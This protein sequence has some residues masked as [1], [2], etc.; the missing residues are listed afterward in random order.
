MTRAASQKRI[1]AQKKWEQLEQDLRDQL[2]GKAET[3]T[4]LSHEEIADRREE[5]SNLLAEA[6]E[7]EGLNSLERMMTHDGASE[8]ARRIYNEAAGGTTP[9]GQ[10]RR[11]TWKSF[12]QFMRAV[13]GVEQDLTPEQKRAL[14]VAREGARAMAHGDP[15]SAKSLEEMESKTLVGD[16]SGSTGRGDYLVPAEHMAELI[17]AMGESQ[18]FLNRTRRIPM[19]RPTAK[20]PRLVQDDGDNTRPIFGFAAVSKIAEGAQKPEREPVFEQVTLQSH[21][22]AAYLEASD[23]LL[24]DS[25]VPAQPLLASLLTEAIAYEADRDGMRGSG[26]GEPQGFIGSDAE[27]EVNRQASVDVQLSDIFN[28]EER[29]FGSD[30]VYLFHPSLIP[31]LYGLADSNVIVFHPNL[32]ESA[33]ATLL[34]RPLIR[35]SKLP[36]LGNT[37][38]LSLVDPQMYLSGVV[39]GIVVESSI[40]YQFRND[41]T[42]FRAIARIA[43]VPALGGTLSHEASGGTK[44]FEVS[45]F[46]VLSAPAS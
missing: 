22:Y 43:G 9:G 17:R 15:I 1:D 27:Y 41:V 39:N 4:R 6:K 28:M 13:A 31:D 10:Q 36:A 33:P 16:D 20:F 7:L 5:I 26:V 2:S 40:H 14:N 8:G 44:T 12:Q 45:P 18:E 29:F 32:A 3:G 11:S 24:S 46:V 37:G 19:V 30:G 34:G 42:A 23:E 38:D 21:K 25:I 35:T